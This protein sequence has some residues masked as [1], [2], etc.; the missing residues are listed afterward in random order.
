MEAA[1][2][3]FA[4]AGLVAIFGVFAAFKAMAIRSLLASWEQTA[5][6]NKYLDL[7]ANIAA[8]GF[9]LLVL[10]TT[11]LR[12]KPTQTAEGWEPKLSAI[13]GTFL[14]LS[15]V[16]VPPANLSPIWRLVSVVLVLSGWVLSI[17][18]LAWLGRSFSLVPQARKLRTRGPYSVVR[19]PLYLSEE[20]SVIGIAL[21][22]ISPIVV[23]IVVVQ[24]MFQ[25]RRMWNEEQVLRSSFPEYA[26]YADRTPM[27]IPRLFRH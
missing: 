12:F 7:T 1:G 16:A 22:S 9:V 27:V 26:A 11:L 23:L 15:L 4:K 18:V 6:A 19:H 3:F 10:A 2:E 5:D 21:M 17:Y 25:L 20:I 8:F 13:I 24:W 14:T